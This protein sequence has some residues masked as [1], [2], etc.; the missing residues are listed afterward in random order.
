[1]IG[2]PIEA[3]APMLAKVCRTSCSLTPSRPVAASFPKTAEGRSAVC[4]AWSLG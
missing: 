4:L 1:M 2:R 3:P